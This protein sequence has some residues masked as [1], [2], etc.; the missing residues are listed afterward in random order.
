MTHPKNSNLLYSLFILST[1]L[2]CVLTQ[3]KCHWRCDECSTY[4]PQVCYSCNYR[5]EKTS[6]FE[7]HPTGCKQNG[8]GLTLAILIRVLVGVFS[9]AMF[10]ATFCC[11]SG[12]LYYIRLTKKG[13]VQRKQLLERIKFINY[14]REIQVVEIAERKPEPSPP[15]P[16]QNVSIPMSFLNLIM[17][18]QVQ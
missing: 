2:C 18:K 1:L 11:A 7:N 5:N 12:G 13:R 4:N 9:L 10:L 8:L 6:D 16:E 14:L 17:G 15:A 3:Q